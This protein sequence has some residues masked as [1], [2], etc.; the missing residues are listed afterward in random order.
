MAVEGLDQRLDHARP[1]GS[2]CRPPS[3]RTRV[4]ARM[5]CRPGR[6]ARRARATPASARRR[7][8]RRA[9]ARRPRAIRL[10]S[11]ACGAPARALAG[12]CERAPASAR[13]ARVEPRGVQ[14]RAHLGGSMRG[15]V[16]R[17]VSL[18]GEGRLVGVGLG[19]GGGGR[20]R[21]RGQASGGRTARM[22][23][24]GGD[25]ANFVR[26]KRGDFANGRRSRRML[27]DDEGAPCGHLGGTA[28]S[29]WGDVSSRP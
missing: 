13:G 20:G 24:S 9:A 11:S 23:A 10:R 29:P 28:P 1:C 22:L 6:E 16:R 25:R 15:S 27:C 8:R 4:A 19:G 12:P 21:G 17:S 2:P 7:R 14:P 3:R 5:R 26:G 18:M